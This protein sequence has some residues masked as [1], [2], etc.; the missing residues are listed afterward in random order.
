[1]T[2]LLQ[3]FVAQRAARQKKPVTNDAQPVTRA[4]FNTL[5]EAV[6]GLIEDFEAATSPEK[7]QEVFSEAFN[8]ALKDAPAVA[9]V[10]GPRGKY[11]VPSDDDESAPK[12]GEARN[13][14]GAK[15]TYI[16]P[17]GD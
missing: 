13:R 7:M 4:E 9:N 1:M 3:Q 17:E 11:L 5:V 16:L 10:A 6:H 12:S 14:R 15:P 8:A 2:N